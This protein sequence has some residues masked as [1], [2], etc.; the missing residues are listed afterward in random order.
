MFVAALI[1]AVAIPGIAEYI[2]STDFYSIV[3]EEEIE[4]LEFLAAMATGGDTVVA[5]RGRSS[6]PIGWWVEGAAR[7]PTISGHDPSFLTFP[8]EIEEAEDANAFFQGD[9]SPDD[10]LDYLEAVDAQYL[11]VDRRGPDAGW[12]FRADRPSFDV[13]Y[14]SPTLVILEVRDQ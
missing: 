11:V 13:I 3:D 10:A 1:G 14:D 2:Q 8:R 12:M 9:L 7:L 5:S 4:A 6:I